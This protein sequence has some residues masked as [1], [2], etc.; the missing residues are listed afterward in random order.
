M[1]FYTT[2]QQQ[3]RKYEEEKY[4]ISGW[5]T[6]RHLRLSNFIVSTFKELWLEEILREYQLF[7]VEN[8]TLM[9]KKKP[10]AIPLAATKIN[11]SIWSRKLR[12]RSRH[13]CYWQSTQQRHR[14]IEFNVNEWKLHF[15]RHRMGWNETIHVLEMHRMSVNWDWK[16]NMKNERETFFFS[17]FSF[18]NFKYVYDKQNLFVESSWRIF[19]CFAVV[20]VIFLGVRRSIDD[21]ICLLR[22][23]MWNLSIVVYAQSNL[24][25]Q[26]P[27][28][29][30]WRTCRQA[31]WKSLSLICWWFKW[32][33]KAKECW[34]II[35]NLS[36]IPSWNESLK[37]LASQK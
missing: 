31:R 4:F 22:V 33:K 29:C 15:I 16:E 34:I 17:S 24:F 37:G 25:G 11:L 35:G 5:M 27:T 20:N 8:L 9:P 14:T 3:P 6:L 21:D 28:L 26:I 7:F 32:Q 10:F 18:H 19:R 23:K 30:W 36:M 2:Q 1:V 13:D 12:S